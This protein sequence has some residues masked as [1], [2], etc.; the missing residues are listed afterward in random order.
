VALFTAILVIVTAI[1][2]AITGY[3]A[4]QTRKSVIALEES[5]KAQFKPF[6]KAS[7]VHLGPEDIAIK[8]SNVGK[9]SA[10]RIRIE[11][12]IT[13]ES[14]IIKKAWEQ[15][16]MAPNDFQTYFIPKSENETETG[17]KFFGT[18]DSTMEIIWTCRDILGVSHEGRAS[19]A[20][21]EYTKQL[22]SPFAVYHEEPNTKIARE[23]EKIE[24]IL[25]K[26][27]KHLK[28]G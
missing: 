14:S 26:I 28:K 27:E 23:I 8:I 13:V 1:I 18:S 25:S 3:Y 21:T 24:D 9:G 2:A 5:T 10:E 17:I 7:I 20:L 11:F 6:L 22:A 12:L 4:K 15:E 16:L 19:I